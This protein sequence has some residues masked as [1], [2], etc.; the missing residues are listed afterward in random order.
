MKLVR[1]EKRWDTPERRMIMPRF[2]DMLEQ[3]RKDYDYLLVD[4]WRMILVERGRSLLPG[5]SSGKPRFLLEME[6]A[7]GGG[8]EAQAMIETL[9]FF[10]TDAITRPMAGIEL[11]NRT[12]EFLRARKRA[13]LISEGNAILEL[14]DRAHSPEQ[15][16]KHVREWLRDVCGLEINYGGIRVPWERYEKRNNLQDP[17]GGEPEESGEF[18]I[19]FAGVSPEQ[20]LMFAFKILKELM[21]IFDRYAD[22]LW[23]SYDFKA[24]REIPVTHLWMDVVGIR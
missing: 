3:M 1:S 14:I 18:L 17:F 21:R 13:D 10:E 9:E 5:T 11:S 8:E 2:L 24:L 19:A 15:L 7:K 6:D 12:R 23:T 20:N 22:G 16:S 4:G